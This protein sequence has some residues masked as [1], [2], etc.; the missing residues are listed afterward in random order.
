MVERPHAEAWNLEDLA[1]QDP[2][3]EANKDIRI[4]PA[5]ALEIVVFDVVREPSLAR[6]DVDDVH[7]LEPRLEIGRV[8][9]IAFGTRAV[10]PAVETRVERIEE[11]ASRRTQPFSQRTRRR[12]RPVADDPLKIDPIRCDHLGHDALDPSGDLQRVDQQP[13]LQRG[14][15]FVQR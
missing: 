14:T 4:Q 8:E 5:Y 1:A 10:T 2:E 11:V 7:A 15:K 13:H 6:C 9:G 3:T 12:G